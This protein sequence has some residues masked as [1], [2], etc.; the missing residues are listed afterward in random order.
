[1]LVS[2]YP[3]RNLDQV[4][5]LPERAHTSPGFTSTAKSCIAF[6]IAFGMAY[7]HSKTIIHFDVKPSNIFLDE[8]YF[9][10]IGGFRFARIITVENVSKPICNIGRPPDMAS[11]TLD[12]NSGAV[13][14]LAYGITLWHMATGRSVAYFKDRVAVHRGERPEM[15]LNVTAALKGLIEK[16]WAQDAG[17]RP[18]FED[19]VNDPECLL[20]PEANRDEYNDF[21]LDLIGKCSGSVN[22]CNGFFDGR[23]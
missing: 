19:V 21:C 12:V 22:G 20:F 15:P 3:P 8:N 11:E 9:P 23:H 14:V 6:G 1:M 5:S 7:L 17:I 16:C 2:E 10:R 18:Q 4:L 13:D